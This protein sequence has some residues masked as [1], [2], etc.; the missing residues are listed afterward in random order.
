MPLPPIDPLITFTAAFLF[1]FLQE[2]NACRYWPSGRGIFHNKQKTFLV[3]V[4][5]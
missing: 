1:S 5:K 3:W 2:A 4:R